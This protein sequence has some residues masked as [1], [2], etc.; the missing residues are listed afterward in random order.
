MEAAYRP[1]IESGRSDDDDEEAIGAD[2]ERRKKQTNSWHEGSYHRLDNAGQGAF[3]ELWQ[4][5]Q[6]ERHSIFSNLF[7]KPDKDEED[8]EEE[9]DDEGREHRKKKKDKKDEAAELD[10]HPQDERTG[11]EGEETRTRQA[12]T[13]PQPAAGNTD[14]PHQRQNTAEEPANQ[15]GTTRQQP[16]SAPSSSGTEQP[17]WQAEDRQKFEDIMAAEMDEDYK[18]AASGDLLTADRPGVEPPATENTHNKNV[19]TEPQ[20]EHE[21]AHSVEGY[22]SSGDQLHQGYVPGPRQPAETLAQQSSAD[23]SYDRFSAGSSEYGVPPV[24][25][26]LPVPDRLFGGKARRPERILSMREKMLAAS[27]MTIAIAGY[28]ANRR[29]KNEIRDQQKEIKKQQKI[30]NEQHDMTAQMAARQTEMHQRLTGQEAYTMREAQQRRTAPAA[31]EHAAPNQPLQAPAE[32]LTPAAPS[33]ALRPAAGM[34]G[35]EAA[36]QQSA[37]EDH[38]EA[39]RRAVEEAR[40]AEE[41]AASDPH[42]RVEQDAWRRYVVDD[43]GHE[44]KNIIQYGEEYKHEREQEVLTDR[45]AIGTSRAR[46]AQPENQGTSMGGMSM[47]MPSQQS[48]RAQSQHSLGSGQAPPDH[49]LPAGMP[50]PADWQHQL[51]EKH[52]SS[53]VAAL[54][55]PWLFLML[56]LILLAYFIASLL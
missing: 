41:A 35:A 53:V 52:R 20:F 19:T 18:K 26:G 17:A 21:P 15:A 13:E 29:R 46:A 12:H 14:L 42:R 30:I 6:A 23:T 33:D 44:I 56:S 47:P 2:G 39:A 34:Y 48:S 25:G 7:E 38:E 3:G 37:V 24:P 36:R 50:T 10:E 32:R 11:G 31:P 1:G 49:S 9:E 51:P 28:F 45:S 5:D 55:S 40:K 4:R 8:D 27:V 16:P 54:T 22:D 43:Q